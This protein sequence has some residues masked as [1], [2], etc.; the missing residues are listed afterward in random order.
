MK[1]EIFE[2]EEQDEAT[3]CASIETDAVALIAELG[4]PGWW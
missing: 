2:I 4:L 3:D 1:V